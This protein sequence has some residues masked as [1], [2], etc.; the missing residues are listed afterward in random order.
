MKHTPF[1]DV[2]YFKLN[3]KLIDIL[4][5]SHSRYILAANLVCKLRKILDPR[6]RIV[7]ADFGRAENSLRNISVVCDS[8]ARRPVQRCSS[9][10]MENAALL[11]VRGTMRCSQQSL[12][13]YSKQVVNAPSC[14]STRARHAKANYRA[15]SPRSKPG[16]ASIVCRLATSR[17]VRDAPLP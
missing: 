5:Y 1:V 3:L 6:D 13:V 12:P 8:V 16:M 15:L 4:H 11:R 14:R 7:I 10:S 17:S 2:I 9:V